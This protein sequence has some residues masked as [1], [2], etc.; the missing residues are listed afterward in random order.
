[1]FLYVRKLCD[2][3]KLL[4][5][6]SELLQYAAHVDVTASC[7]ARQSWRPSVVD[8]RPSRHCRKLLILRELR[9]LRIVARR[10]DV[11]RR[12]AWWMKMTQKNNVNSRSVFSVDDNDSDSWR[13]LN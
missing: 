8:R 4:R 11:Q 2:V 1:L 3:Y 12:N 6:S 10:K 13:R 5:N 7:C 9:R